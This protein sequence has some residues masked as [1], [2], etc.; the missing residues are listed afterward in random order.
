MRRPRLAS[1]LLSIFILLLC[2]IPKDLHA[3]GAQA[4][5]PRFALVMGNGNYTGTSKLANPAN[6]AED[7]GDALTR[8]GFSTEVLTNA[9]LEAMETAVLGFRDRLAGS[10]DSVG[11]FFYAGHGVQSAGEN[12]LIPVDVQIP[13]ESLLRTRAV[14]LHFVLDSLRE[15]KNKLNVVILDAC[16]DNPFAWAR[17]GNRGLSIVGA[18][19]PGSI[20]VYSTS[21]GSTAQDGTGRN[22][23][24]TEV[25]LNHLNYPGLEINEIFR[26]TGAG[27]QEKT[28]GAQIPA[29]YSQFFGSFYP[30]GTQTAPAASDDSRDDLP[31]FFFLPAFFEDAPVYAK[32]AIDAAEEYTYYGQWLSAWYNLLDAD[33]LERDPYILAQK[34]SVALNGHIDHENYRGF[35]FADLAEGEEVD[36]IRYT[37][38]SGSE[39]YYFDPHNS[40]I[41]M[42]RKGL[43]IPPILALAMGDYYY[44]LWF[45]YA[46][47]SEDWVKSQ[48]EAFDLAIRCYRTAEEDYILVNTPS[49]LHYAELL[50]QEG[51][52]DKTIELLLD[53]LEWEPENIQARKAL[54]E[55]YTVNLDLDLAFEQYDMLAA[56]DPYS[57]QAYEAYSYAAERALLYGKINEFE[58]YVTSLETFFPDDWLALLLRH[59]IAASSADWAKAAA[60]A[61]EGL[62]R[63]KGEVDVLDLLLGSWL[64]TA[65]GYWEG[66][67]FLE[68]QILKA[69]PDQEQLVLLL[70]YRAAY[71]YYGLSSAILTDTLTNVQLIEEDLNKAAALNAKLPE[72]NAEMESNI[73]SLRAELLSLSETQ[74][75]KGL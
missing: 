20:V 11:L 31:E 56:P 29:I 23:A 73:K 47:F 35:A 16:R 67:S 6:D 39:F 1:L 59:R 26:R 37:E 61:E 48:D 18:Q 64:L 63:F 33:P 43:F 4:A 72:V 68:D 19:P 7:M 52:S 5:Q 9:G 17:S 62:Q 41:E 70:F 13:S 32:K 46:A 69:Q 22:G 28:L 75:D 74:E 25:L 55:A 57:E 65:E 60:L 53:V 45:N 71:R 51:Q 21:A 30:S 58:K 24:F 8:L 14:S 66:F 12:Y 44:S 54:A 15:A 3:Q 40:F 10:P 49:M 50:L 36:A 42:E 2:L 27:V 38:V 34:V